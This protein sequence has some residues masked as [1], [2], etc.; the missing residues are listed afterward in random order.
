MLRASPR[1]VNRMAIDGGVIIYANLAVL[2]LLALI[3]I[4]RFAASLRGNLR[5][6]SP[7]PN[8][9]KPMAKGHSRR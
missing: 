9:D 1:S 6:F 3:A 8:I 2:I 4:V 5:A 7:C